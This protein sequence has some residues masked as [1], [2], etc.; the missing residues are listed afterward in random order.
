LRRRSRRPQLNP[1]T[2]DEFWE[3][4]PDDHAEPIEAAWQN[5]RRDAIQAAVNKLPSPQRQALSLAFFEDLTQDQVANMLDL[6]LGTVKTRI[7]SGLQKI[8][9]HLM[10]LGIVVVL[11]GVLSILGIRYHIQQTDLEREAKAL[12]MATMSDVTTTH[13]PPAQGIPSETH[14][15]YRTRP[16]SSTVVLALHNFP[17]APAGKV[18]QG[19]VLHQGVWISLG[20]AKPDLQ[21]DAVLIG[22]NPG[23]AA[24]PETIQVTLEPEGTSS[25]PTGPVIIILKNP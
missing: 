1:N 25:T 14:G 24:P 17:T 21:G 6:P 2:D 5:Y 10:P 3:D 12:Q 18:Y 13:I 20:T 4:L 15:S 7:R 8:R 19:W 22:D 23:L 9:A 16:G 11:I